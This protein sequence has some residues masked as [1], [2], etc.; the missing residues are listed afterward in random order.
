MVRIRPDS[1][2]VLR[3]VCARCDFVAATREG[4]AAAV[5]AVPDATEARRLARAYLALYEHM[6][7]SG[8]DRGHTQIAIEGVLFDQGD[9][10]FASITPEEVAR[11]RLV[12]EVLPA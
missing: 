7:S 4:T 10:L 12:A 1:P 8:H 2:A 6:A 9:L 3:H 5:S 11:W